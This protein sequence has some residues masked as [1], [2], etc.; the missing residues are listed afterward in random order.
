MQVVR[1]ASETDFA[2][3][4]EAARSLRAHGVP[5]EAALWT[6]DGAGDLFGEAAP[7]PQAGA[8]PFTVPREFLELADTVILHRSDERFALLYRLL[9]RLQR[10]P[11]L[12]RIASDPD[13]AQARSFAKQVSQAAHKMKAF[14]RFRQMQDEDG[15]IYVAWFEPPHR[16][17]EMTAP[18][19][20]RRFANM[21]FSILTP[22]L[23]A[24]WDTRQLT[25]TPGADAADAPREDALEDYWKTYYASIFNPA[26]LK[27]AQMQK[28]MPKRYWR[29]LPEAG[30]IPELIARAEA[31]TEA[32][33]HQAPTE[34]SKRALKAA[35]RLTR[36]APFDGQAPTTI[37]E[38]WAGVQACRRCDLW[39]CGT[40]GVAG[41][42]PV[43]ARL[44]FVGEQPGD[45]E[46]LAGKPFVGPAG[47][48]LDKALAEAGVPR[49]ETF[50]TN[51]VK[52]FKH[53][54][55]GK[56]R[57]HRNPD[58]GEISACRWWLDNERRIVR[59]RV[60]VAL[61]G[62]ASLAV[63]GKTLAVSK[64]RQQAMQLPDQTQGV[65]TYHPS[66]LLR[67]PD[68]E[69]KAKGYRMFVE[70]LKFAWSLAAG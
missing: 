47:Q 4:R 59:P 23:C 34:P 3:W 68:A 16:V 27:T 56:R 62:S 14:V 19:F 31:Q 58:A 17:V 29:N 48:V 67:V 54:L 57:L 33:V 6:V 24:H 41:E 13:V 52:H 61:G 26:R 32:M 12:L 39:R 18:F 7:A 66:Y 49:A 60:I 15:E 21:R 22:D 36:D 44:M 35:Q 37:E 65:V 50:V 28:E 55:R 63:F 25:F 10:E 69:A 45:Q 64:F 11:N 43:K 40:Q 51:A 2:G 42:G 9:W 20:A 8:P 70:D 5:P 46:D 30:L 53:E 38:V 1:L